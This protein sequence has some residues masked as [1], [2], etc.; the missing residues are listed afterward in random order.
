MMYARKY[1]VVTQILFGDF[2]RR[3]NYENNTILF[4]FTGKNIVI[5]KKKKKKKLISI[6]EE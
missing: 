1:V 5:T 3:I 2:S 6:R 4:I